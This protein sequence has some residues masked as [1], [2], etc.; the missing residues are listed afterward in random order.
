MRLCRFSLDDMILTGFYGDNAV[1]PVDHAAEAYS[2][3]TGIELLLPSTEDLLDLLPP[4]GCSYELARDLDAWVSELD[5]VARNELAIDVQDVQIL[6][7]I[8]GPPKLLF[9]AG[10][11]ARHISE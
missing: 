2:Q 3:A 10:N 1:I 9:L 4:D 5:I 8:A 7:P 6:V 11:Y